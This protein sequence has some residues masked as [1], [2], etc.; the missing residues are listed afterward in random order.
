MK[1]DFWFW[2]EQ[3]F[4]AV[5]FFGLMAVLYVILAMMFPDPSVW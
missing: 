1:E 4:T 3:I 2:V 5:L